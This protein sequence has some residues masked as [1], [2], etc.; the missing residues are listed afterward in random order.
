MKD[1]E[2]SFQND[3]ENRGEGEKEIELPFRFSGI[4]GAVL[5]FWC[6][7]FL[8][9][10]TDFDLVFELGSLIWDISNQVR[11]LKLFS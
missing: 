1:L 3:F 6:H 11:C 2:T 4:V 5:L 10:D 7:C 9:R 8:Q